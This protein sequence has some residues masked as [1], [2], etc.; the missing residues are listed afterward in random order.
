MAILEKTYSELI[1]FPTFEERFEYLKLKGSIGFNTFGGRRWLNQRFYHSEEWKR[2]RE[3]IIL[4]DDGCDLGIE[5]RPIFGRAYI[6][7]IVPIKPNDLIHSARMV[8]DPENV[9][10]VSF[11]THNA[12][13]YGGIESVIRDPIERKPFDTCPWKEA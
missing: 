9:I 4:R 2:F 6:H 5:D 12:I 13:H 7:H 1:S 10:L 3:A 11:D 8:L